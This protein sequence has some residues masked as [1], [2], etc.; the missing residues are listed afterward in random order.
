M[1][2]LCDETGKRPEGPKVLKSCACPV[3]WPLWSQR[4]R[5]LVLT[6]RSAA[7][8]DGNGLVSKLVDTRTHALTHTTAAFKQAH[9]VAIDQVHYK[10]LCYDVSW[11]FET[12]LYI[13]GIL[14]LVFECSSVFNFDDI[15][16]P[17]GAFTNLL[18][19]VT[20]VLFRIVVYSCVQRARQSRY[21]EGKKA[22][23]LGIIQLFQKR[24][25]LWSVMHGPCFIALSALW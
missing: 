6:K 25:L 19:I 17:E 18:P 13:S 2:I 1:E 8:G 22:L 24:L 9:R 11:F 23:N 20:L 4:S 3:F 21:R 15:Q 14:P 12:V 5:F 16:W 10:N 7:S